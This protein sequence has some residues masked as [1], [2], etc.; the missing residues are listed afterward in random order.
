M[1][2]ATVEAVTGWD[3]VPFTDGHAGLRDLADREFTGAVTTGAAWLFMLNGRV[4]GVFDGTI[5]S[6]EA[7]DGTAYEAPHPSL[8]LLFTMQ[9]HGGETRAKY[10]SE[11]TP[12]S[13]VDRTLKAGKFTGF[14]ELSENV[15]SGDY[16]TVYHGGKS[17]SAA[18]V[19][20]NRRLIT[21]DEAFQRADDEVGIYEVRTVDIDVVEIPAAPA[22][23]AGA[24]EEA[25]SDAAAS[26]AGAAASGA[27]GGVADDEASDEMSAEA[28]DANVDDVANA[29]GPSQGG[30]TFGDDPLGDD[31]LADDEPTGSEPTEATA[32]QSTASDDDPLAEPD[33]TASGTAPSTA[34][35]TPSVETEPTST[36]QSTASDDNTETPDSADPNRSADDASAS[37]TPAE[38]SA[39]DDEADWRESRTI[40][41]LD[42]EN[43][44]AGES[45]DANGSPA[46]TP[47]RS[48]TAS[49]ESQPSK[50]KPSNAQA[51]DVDQG[52]ARQQ[53]QSAES[54]LDALEAERD[55][56]VA[57]LE[58]ATEAKEHLERER[59]QLRQAN[60]QAGQQ[61]S[62]LETRVAELE[63]TIETLE[64][65]L[66]DAEP[67][68]GEAA[69]A[70]SGLD[71]PI[72]RALEGTNLFVRYSRKSGAT[73]DDAF[74]GTA[75]REEV[76]ENIRLEH[77]TDFDASG[78]SVEGEPFVDWLE[79]TIEFGFSRWL[80]TEF[81]H[82]IRETRNQSSLEELYQAIPD[83]DRVEF[84]GGIEIPAEDGSAQTVT[85]DVVL[86]DRMGEPLVVADLNDSR[87][88][89]TE[90]M[91]ESLVENA[92]PIGEYEPALAG[93]F[94]V[95]T[96][97]FEPGALE[98][99]HEATGGGLLRR[100]RRKSF[101]KL[102]RKQGYHLC[103]V[104]TRNGE[105][106]VNVPEL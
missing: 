36:G 81:I 20:N 84:Q 72:D 1:E 71:V 33:D 63:A 62:T 57:R 85:F 93:A 60:E 67:S 38:R 100:D 3:S 17:M 8:P 9:E 6:F 18:F 78:A 59:Q 34:D 40:P 32:E 46:M 24:D 10:Y 58:E 104:E 80:V 92:S 96:S 105:F 41:A 37:L 55:E 101:V 53:L 12:L 95:T 51:R 21:D 15:L 4:I 45:A 94:F 89:A 50:S 102:S 97:Y 69:A 14:V 76:N 66:E 75:S 68:D 30:V 98:T 26:G 19:G 22:G 7:E 61:I 42:P 23:N 99:A 79:S 52:Q 13:E 90:P 27:V 87:E 54:S 16:Y 31:P 82:D 64:A 88:P 83:I 35:S 70:S 48:E 43:S 28:A 2:S 47:T 73:L 74:D 5:D 44:T 65:E 56:L 25:S 49:G 91:L 103:L 29:D 106:H 86:R 77:H 39:F 11:K